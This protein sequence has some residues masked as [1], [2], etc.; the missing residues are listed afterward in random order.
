MTST[1]TDRPGVLAPT[2]PTPDQDSAPYWEGL[3][4]RRVRVQACVECG[5]RRFP[6]V[7]GC[8]YCAH[9]ESRWEDAAGTGVVYSAIVVHRTLDPEF[10]ADVPYP[11]ATVDLDGGGRLLARTEGEVELDARVHPVFVDHGDWTELRFAST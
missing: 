11:I 3:R 8:P 10:A 9:P 7:P 4:E 6:P 1:E 2:G 5:R